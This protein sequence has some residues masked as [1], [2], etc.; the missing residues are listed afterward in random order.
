MTDERIAGR[1]GLLISTYKPFVWYKPHRWLSAAIRKFT[2]SKWG[3]SAAL[4]ELWGEWYV[5]EYDPNPKITAWEQWRNTDKVIQVA[6]LKYLY[7]EKMWANIAL[8]KQDATK[9][10]Y[11]SLFIYQPIYQITG[12]W[13][14]RKN[15]EGDSRFYCSEYIAWVWNKQLVNLFPKWWQTSPADLVNSDIFQPLY[16]GMA[17]QLSIV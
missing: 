13:V 15:K 10:D 9:Y 11:A 16:E 5:I 6:E 1:T 14:G 4:I 8:S 2:G 17:N 3:H 12:Q 7:N